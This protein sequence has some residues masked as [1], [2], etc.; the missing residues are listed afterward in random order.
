[1]LK[2]FLLILFIYFNS[3]Y[4]LSKLMNINNFT[5]DAVVY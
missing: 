1:M 2:E 3:N 5:A 4:K